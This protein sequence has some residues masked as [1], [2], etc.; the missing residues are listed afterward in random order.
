MRIA[1]SR[2]KVDGSH[3]TATMRATSDA[4]QRL[5][6][7]L[8]A[9]TRR[10]EHH[11]IEDVELGGI[12]RMAHQVAPC[13]LDG[14]AATRP[15]H[16][17]FQRRDGG[18]V[19]VDRPHGGPA[20]QRQRE[21]AEAAERVEHPARVADAGEH[22]LGQRRLPL[23]RRLQERA[24][25]QGHEHTVELHLRRLAGEQDLVT[26]RNAQDRR[27]VRTDAQGFLGA[28]ALA[29][30]A[31]LLR[32]LRFGRRERDV[33]AVGAERRDQPG[34]AALS[35]RRAGDVAQDRE[36]RVEPR[37]QRRAIR[38]V[39]DVV[40]AAGEV[41]DLAV[42]RRQRQPAAARERGARHRADRR[43]EP[44]PGERVDHAAT[45]PLGVEPIAEVLEPAAAA[46]AEQRT[47]RHRTIPRERLDDRAPLPAADAVAGDGERHRPAAVLQ[48]T[49]AGIVE[50]D[51]RLVR[52]G[53][54]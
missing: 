18:R 38:H 39:D 5:G 47:G 48:H 37:L 45:L 44:V 36:E 32:L 26:L 12:E 52:G 41:A 33:D 3:D 53:S 40:G 8:G 22:R 15:A 9:G 4:R 10:V 27:V 34:L 25:R 46:D 13:G 24:G 42:L 17:R 20:R 11:R 19:A 35:C 50:P 29:P 54:G 7:R 28:R 31:G 1:Q 30:P 23:A 51:D 2:A 14:L 21:R 16:G 6:E 49:V 43:L